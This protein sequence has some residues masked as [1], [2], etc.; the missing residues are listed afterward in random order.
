MAERASA[1]AAD[2]PWSGLLPPSHDRAIA[3]SPGLVVVPMAGLD[4]ATLVA[5]EGGAGTL[6]VRLAEHFG[7]DL[8]RRPR[9]SAGPDLT[10]IWA[11]RNQWLAVSPRHG[12]AARL[13]SAVRDAAAV[14][15]QGSSRALL[16]LSGSRLRDVLAKGCA[17]DLHPAAFAVGDVAMTAI[18]HVGVHLWRPDEASLVVS[19]SR[20]YAGSFWSW[21]SA[22]AAEFGLAVGADQGAVNA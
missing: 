22:S 14:S 2:D 8:P 18:S 7:V 17:V 6:A 5:P 10:L 11:G 15:D 12:V 20:S 21:L 3:G 13:A 9:L 19:V 16:W 4:L 1:W